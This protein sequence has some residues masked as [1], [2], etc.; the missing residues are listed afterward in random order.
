MQKERDLRR[1]LAQ[2][3]AETRLLNL[4]DRD[5]LCHHVI[6]APQSGHVVA[7]ALT[8]RTVAPTRTCGASLL[9]L[10]EEDGVAIAIL[11]RLRGPALPQVGDT[12]TRRRRCVVYRLL[13]TG[14][15]GAHRLFVFARLGENGDAQTKSAMATNS[16]VTAAARAMHA[17]NEAED[18]GAAGDAVRHFRQALQCY[19]RALGAERNEGARA[20]LNEQ[21]RAIMER[22]TQLQQDEREPVAVGGPAQQQPPLTEQGGRED[23][24][25][26]RE[27]E[28]L[29]IEPGALQDAPSWDDVIGLDHVKRLLQNWIRLPSEMPHL[30]QGA[31]AKLKNSLL[32]YG[33]P[34][35]GKTMAVR[36]LAASSERA[37]FAIKSSDLISKWVGDSAK[38][39]RALFDV[40]KARKPCILFLDEFD[41]LCVARDSTSGQ[42][43]ESSKAVSEFLIQ[44]DGITKDDTRGVLLICATNLP[45]L[46][47]EAV[48]RRLR[49]RLHVQLPN[50]DERLRL[51]VHQLARFR[52]PLQERYEAGEDEAGELEALAEALD[53]FSCAD[54]VSLVEGADELGM[55]RIMETRHFRSVTLRSDDGDFYVVPCEA[56][57]AGAKAITYGEIAQKDVIRPPLLRVAHLRERLGR[58]KPSV[59]Q[60]SLTQYEAWTR[61][62]GSAEL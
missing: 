15:L 2:L 18:R 44:C 40:V 52:D 26:R 56:G 42:S 13:V 4:K 33:P 37:L 31:R 12:A 39:V 62:Y 38:Y 9:V 17:A 29:C 19:Q 22:I 11:L 50:R 3:V 51:L 36:A 27:L 24:R 41:A 48:L 28:A 47:D 23:E 58:A 8:A 61:K 35:I 49:W 59:S 46:L 45:A 54:I 25:M 60:E 21:A 1:E 20:I 10:F 14:R 16:H 6:L 53:G 34:G 5:L 55:Q 57:E 32:L 43:A 7:A 30:Y